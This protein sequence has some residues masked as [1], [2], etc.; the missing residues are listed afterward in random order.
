MRK[1]SD[2]IFYDSWLLRELN[3]QANEEYRV[4]MDVGELKKDASVKLIG[5][6]DVDNHYG[7]VVFTDQNGNILEVPGDY[8]GRN[9]SS[10]EDLKSALSKI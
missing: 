3:M 5:F 9:H 6:D 2:Y 1:L 10:V 8:S 7:I 4:L